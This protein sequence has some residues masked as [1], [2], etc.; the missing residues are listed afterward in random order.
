[1]TWTDLEQAFFASAPPEEP[2]SAAEPECFDD[3]LALSP[4]RGRFAGLRGALARVWGALR[5]LT[6]RSAERR[7]LAASSPR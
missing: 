4:Q 6:I 1:M 5:R 3:L 2:G 7:R